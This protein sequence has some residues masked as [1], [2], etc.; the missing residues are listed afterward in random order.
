ME[1]QDSITRKEFD[2]AIQR[3]NHIFNDIQKR[4]DNLENNKD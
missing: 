4:L 1:T 2:N 3:M